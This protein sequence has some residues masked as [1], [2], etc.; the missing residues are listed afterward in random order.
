MFCGLACQSPLLGNHLM[1]TWIRL[2]QG[3][4][5][6][7]R[8]RRRWRRQRRWWRAGPRW[9]G[10]HECCT[11]RWRRGQ[12]QH[13]TAGRRCARAQRGDQGVSPPCGAARGLANPRARVQGSRSR[14]CS[15]RDQR[16][17]GRQTCEAA[18]GTAGECARRNRA[19]AC[20]CACACR[21]GWRRRGAWARGRRARRGAGR[22]RRGRICPARGLGQRRTGRA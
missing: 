20:A 22:T 4:R 10:A 17:R 8:R 19:C 14:A 7:R 9:A 11:P 6:R 13:C 5:R 2:A 1:L 21:W 18:A 15:S 16:Q 12:G 3:R